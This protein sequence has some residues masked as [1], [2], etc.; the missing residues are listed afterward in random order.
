MN[1]RVL[2]REAKEPDF[3]LI[4][5]LLTQLWP[6]KKL[7]KSNLEKVYKNIIKS[8]ESEALCALIDDHIVGFCTILIHDSLWQESKMAHIGEIIVDESFR[9]QRIGTKLLKKS[10]VI[11]KNKGCKKVEL[12]SAFHRE[13]AHKFYEKLGFENRAYLFS[14]DL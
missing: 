7:N 3:G 2:I 8:E 5:K 10:F 11:A 1:P 6:G 9:G 13:K 14:K 12:D 4:L